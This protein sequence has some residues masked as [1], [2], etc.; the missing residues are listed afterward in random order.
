M[1][2]LQVLRF[3]FH[4]FRILEILYFHPCNFESSQKMMINYPA[5]KEIKILNPFMPIGISRPYHLDASIANLR[6]VG[7]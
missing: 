4:K 1:G 6:V 5:C 7:W 3:E 2:I